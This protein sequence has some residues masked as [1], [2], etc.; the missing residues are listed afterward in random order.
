MKRPEISV[1]IP[2]YNAEPF[3]GQAIES[4]LSQ[5]WKD[6][7]LIVL[8]NKSTDNTLAVIRKYKDKRL[9]V[10]AHKKNLGAQANWNAAVTEAKGRFVKILCA[11]DYMY[12][13]CLAKQHAV[14]SRVQNAALV[15]AARDIVDESGKKI[16]RRGPRKAE[17][18]EGKAAVR[19]T[20]R[21]GTNIY[22]ET[23]SAL[24][25]AE[26]R[27]SAG[28]FDVSIPY[29]IDLDMWCRILLHGD[30][31]LMP[32]VVSAYR[33]GASSWSAEIMG[34]QRENFM[35]FIERVR[36]NPAYELTAMDAWIGRLKAAVQ[37]ALRLAF[38]RFVLGWRKS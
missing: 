8:D 31:V 38:Y 4:A 1:C 16:M 6:F 33:V 7:E 23:S 9:R 30:L 19:R 37:A 22:G 5:T 28:M 25:R 32:E 21:G 12:P 20:I 15:C 14:L 34:K 36:A 29:V 18:V 13:E 17:I 24:F 26:A 27:A 2:V 11:D 3:I 10:I 35:R